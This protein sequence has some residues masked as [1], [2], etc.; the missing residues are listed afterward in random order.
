ML[1]ISGP[2]SIWQISL[3]TVMV[4]LITE[5]NYGVTMVRLTL[6]GGGP[7]AVVEDGQLPKHLPR[8]HGAQLHALLCHLHLP[9]CKEKTTEQSTLSHFPR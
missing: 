8:T 1:S 9:I 3:W 2:G 5:L 7:G 4:K 6:D